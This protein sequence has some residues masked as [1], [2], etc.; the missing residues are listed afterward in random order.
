VTVA[1]G[2]IRSALAGQRRKNAGLTTVDYGGYLSHRWQDDD[3]PADYL[4]VASPVMIDGSQVMARGYRATAVSGWGRLQTPQ[5]R[6]EAELA[7][8]NASVDQPSLIPGVE[9]GES[10]TSSQL[11][12]ALESDYQVAEIFDAGFDTGYASGDSA[13]GFGAF[14]RANAPAAQAGDL[15]GPQASFDGDNTVDNFRFH[16]D[17]RI[18]KLLFREIIGTV[19][20]AIY[21]RPHA[22]LARALGPGRVSLSVAVI[23]SWAAE[24]NS[25]PSGER[26]LGIELDPTLRYQAQGFI[27][28]LDYALL[29]PGAAFDNPVMGISPEPAQL[30]RMRLEY[31]F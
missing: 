1:A 16:P 22:R 5:L 24:A 14:P 4:P 7:Y 31:V 25:T 19:T 11:G 26:F 8:L 28:N 29:M 9:L 3:V 30:V 21:M 6:L 12:L 20:D 23:A 10:A 13:P 18:D 2:R 27:A 17:Y 15:D